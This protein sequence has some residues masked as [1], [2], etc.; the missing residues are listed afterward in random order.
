MAVELTMPQMDQTMT[1]GTIGKW[2]VTE[3]D[4][5]KEGD[6]VLEIETDKVV[7]EMESPADGI[8]AQI[9]AEDGSTVP[10]NAV[11]AIITAPGEKVER[12]DS[13]PIPTEKKVEKP[14]PALMPDKP[15]STPLTPIKASPVARHLAEAQNIDLAQVKGSGPGG[16]I[17]EADVQIYIERHVPE[18]V[19]S[20]RLK[21]SPLAR[22]LAKEHGLELKT[23][24]GSGPDG[25]IVRDDVLRAVEAAKIIPPEPVPEI[26]P[27]IAPTQVI[28]MTGMR[29]IIA[30]RMTLSSQAAASVTLNT[31]VDVTEFV[32]L[33]NLLNQK[34]SAKAVKLSYTDLLVKVVANALRQYPRLN[35][36]LKEDGIHLMEEINI[37]IAVAL[38]D[39]LVVPVITNADKKGLSTISNEIQTF[40]E[41]ARNNQLSPADLR[42]GTFTITNLGMFGIDTFTPIINPPECAILGVGRI[43]K[44]PIV[45][46]G[47]IKIRSMMGLSLSFDHRIVDGTPAAQFLQTVTEYIGEPY[48]LLV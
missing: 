47:E 39:G 36:T 15:I 11:L 19:E 7:H 37:G 4:T 3:G 32:E 48:L 35:S 1:T 25:R 43:V 9:L 31:E 8:I 18:P 40:A 34:L 14:P 12:R 26:S 44:K 30:D 22:R 24:A 38:E 42:G 27:E 2:L 28:P 20:G 45:H 29:Q 33:R 5:V 10:V 6:P 41:N 13:A 21:A 16:R 23:L 17:V 46:E